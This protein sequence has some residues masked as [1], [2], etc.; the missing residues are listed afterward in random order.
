MIPK[1]SRTALAY[2]AGAI[3]AFVGIIVLIGWQVDSYALKTFGLGS[4]SMKANTAACFLLAG[5]ALVVMQRPKRFSNRIVSFHALVIMLVGTLSLFHHFFGLDI[6]LE[7]L[8]YHEPSL[9]SGTSHPGL[10]APNTALNFLLIGI[11]LFL[12]TLKRFWRNYLMEFSL[13]FPLTISLIGLVGYIIGF[14]ELSGPAAYTRMAF[15]TSVTFI[16]LCLGILITF[17]QRQRNPITIEQKLF[18]GLTTSATVIIFISFLSITGIQSLRQA[19]S[20]VKHTQI[21]KNQVG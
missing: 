6:G 19:S 8:L 10:M 11:A 15:N 3:T 1:L 17:S 12:F 9:T 5:L 20:W 7:E 16:F 4:V 2:T 14:D 18:A 21:V 13:I